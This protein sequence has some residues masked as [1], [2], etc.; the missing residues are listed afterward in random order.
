MLQNEARLKTDYLL[1]DE[2]VG[3]SGVNLMGE[4]E[5]REQL[6][7]ILAE[8]ILHKCITLIAARKLFPL[9]VGGIWEECEPHIIGIFK[10]ILMEAALS[11]QGENVSV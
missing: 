11:V 1:W 8:G 7:T 3:E 2:V 10:K 9:I 4:A 6:A 5:G